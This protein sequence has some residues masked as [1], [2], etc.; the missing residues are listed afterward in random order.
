MPLLH[1]ACLQVRHWEIVLNVRARADALGGLQIAPWARGRK[2]LR[3]RGSLFVG[4]IFGC[5][6]VIRTK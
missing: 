6:V 2:R 3:V 1:F 4:R 5:L